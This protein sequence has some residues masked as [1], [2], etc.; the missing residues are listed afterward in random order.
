MDDRVVQT[1]DMALHSGDYGYYTYTC[2]WCG[3]VIRLDVWQKKQHAQLTVGYHWLYTH[4]IVNAIRK[5]E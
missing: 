5:T 2:G 1:A 3:Q 4:E